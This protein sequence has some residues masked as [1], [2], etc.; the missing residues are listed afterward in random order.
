MKRI[1][2]VEYRLFI[3]SVLDEMEKKSG[4]RFC[5]ETV[6]QFGSFNYEIVV[7]ESH[8]GK[9]LIWTLHGLRAPELAMPAFG[10]AQ[11]QKTYFDFNGR[12]RFILRKS[13]GTEGTFDLE[14]RGR[15]IVLRNLLPHSFLSVELDVS[16]TS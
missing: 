15:H 2:E 7:N 4:L 5:L 11:F 14:A 9:T 12:H 16:Q 13:D 3:R 1:A 6:K 8:V 10:S